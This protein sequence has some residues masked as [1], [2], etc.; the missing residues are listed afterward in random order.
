[1]GIEFGIT[2]IKRRKTGLFIPIW[3]ADLFS[4][5]LKYRKMERRPAVLFPIYPL[6]SL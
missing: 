1:M 6:K 2:L 5:G 4:D 3:V